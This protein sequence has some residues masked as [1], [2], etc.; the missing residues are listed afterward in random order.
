MK[1]AIIARKVGMT[2]IFSEDGTILPVTVLEA[3]PCQVV[4][5]KNREKDG[6][7]SVQLSFGQI[8]D[9]NVT[10]PMRGHYEK[11]NA[12][13][14]RVLKEFRLEDSASYNVGDTV[15]SSAFEVGDR[16]DVSG[17]SKGK[18]FQGTIKRHGMSRGPMSHGSKYHRAVGSMGGSS[19]PSR[20]FKGKKLPG[21]MGNVK[22]TVQNLSVVKVD[23]GKNLILVKGSVPGRNGTIVT[24]ADTVKR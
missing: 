2:Q 9:K 3:G 20:V 13:P 19:D 22:K 17:T 11:A 8:K 4:Q 10:Q 21:Q 15:S 18:G 7:E 12:V 14:Q 24:I 16:V 6:Y 23:E 5:V 1:K